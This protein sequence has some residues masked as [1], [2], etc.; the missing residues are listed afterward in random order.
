MRSRDAQ[1]NTEE[2]PYQPDG[3]I[4]VAEAGFKHLLSY[5]KRGVLPDG[6]HTEPIKFHMTWAGDSCVFLLDFLDLWINSYYYYL[7]DNNTS[8][9]GKFHGFLFPFSSK[10]SDLNFTL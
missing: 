8:P 6:I 7:G 3:H 1:C 5:D 4:W 2:S 9:H 10:F